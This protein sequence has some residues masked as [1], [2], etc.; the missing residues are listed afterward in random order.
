MTE[1][2]KQNL[3]TKK[4]LKF[5]VDRKFRVLML[6]DIQETLN[7]DRRTLYAMDKIVEAAKPDL[8]VLGGDNE[9]GK[10]FETVEQFKEYL[11]NTADDKTVISVV[12][13]LAGEDA[14][15]EGGETDG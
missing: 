15:K 3:Y 6:S 9:N 4:P 10:K 2:L 12:L 14:D 5:G 1:R 13:E 7:Y 11:K 8:V